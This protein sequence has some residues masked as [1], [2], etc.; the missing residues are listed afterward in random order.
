MFYS[1]TGTV[2]FTD[3]SA[4]ALDCGGVAF[5]LNTTANTL[6]KC[7][8]IGEM[9]T[10]YT[11]LSVR[12]DALDLFGFADKAELDCYKTLIGVTGVGP[13]AAI[14]ILSALTP[15]MLAV[16][17]AGEEAPAPY[18]EEKLTAYREGSIQAIPDEAFS[19]LLGGPIPDG[20]WG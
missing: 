5:Y 18:D 7:A 3:E 12:E 17:V 2:V 8:G 19:E 14:A 20:S 9:Q 4:I 15:D 11:Y 13:K 1:L 10:L 16:A 6:R